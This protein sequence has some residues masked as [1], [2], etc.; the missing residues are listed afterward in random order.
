M[1]GTAEDKWL[2]RNVMP[3]VAAEGNR[4]AHTC[5]QQPA[6]R[7]HSPN[8]CRLQ[9]NDLL[10]LLLSDC[11]L[12]PP[13]P[14][15]TCSVPSPVAALRSACQPV[16]SSLRMPSTRNEEYRYTDI[17]PLLAASLTMAP[18]DAAVSAQQLEELAVPEAAGSRVVLVN[19]AFRPELSDLSAVAGGAAGLYVGAAAGAPADALQQL[20][21]CSCAVGSRR[22]VL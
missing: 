9:T 14:Q 6:R 2:A 8:T 4:C 17:S 15:H 11:F 19:G 20:V 5:S 1:V 13:P 10:L 18:A 7:R 21:S 16:L 12:S 3:L 22:I